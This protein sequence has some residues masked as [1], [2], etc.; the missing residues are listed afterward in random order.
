MGGSK[1]FWEGFN[2]V[3]D[4]FMEGRRLYDMVRVRVVLGCCYY[5]SGSYYKCGLKYLFVR[6]VKQHIS[7]GEF[8]AWEEYIMR[9]GG[10]VVNLWDYLMEVII[11]M[12]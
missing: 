2:A 9:G 10:G 7:I 11:N 8:S 6:G 5:G 3:E 1:C 12:V 4:G